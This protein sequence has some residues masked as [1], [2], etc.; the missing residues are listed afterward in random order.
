MPLYF[1]PL[2]LRQ[3]SL[4]SDGSSCILGYDGVVVVNPLLPEMNLHHCVRER[5]TK[6]SPSYIL[7]LEYHLFR[8]TL[9]RINTNKQIR[10]VSPCHLSI[11]RLTINIVMG[12]LLGG[13]DHLVMLPAIFTEGRSVLESSNVTVSKS[14]EFTPRTPF[15]K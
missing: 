12:L 13:H 7:L 10:N 4:V 9:L 5:M 6:A 11:S 2:Y 1:R 3:A 14:F 15:P 8:G